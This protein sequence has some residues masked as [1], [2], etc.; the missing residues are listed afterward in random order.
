MISI[1][2]RPLSS[3]WSQ[4]RERGAYI[5]LRTMF[6][7]YRLLGRR[8]FQLMLTPVVG[9]FYLTNGT[10]RAA[11]IHFLRCVHDRAG[12]SADA[13]VPSRLTSFRHFLSFGE[14]IGD[15]IAAWAGDI[16]PDDVDLENAAAFDALR[17]SGRGGIL[18]A[19]H[20]GNMEVCRA[21]S[22]AI[23]TLR[24]T[25]LLHT[26]HSKN[27]TRLMRNVAP[28]SAL[29]IIQTTEMTP[30]T[31]M[32][33]SERVSRGEFIVIAGDRTPVSRSVRVAWAPF[34]G[35]PA[36]FPQGPFIL[37]GLLKCPV[38]LLFCLKHGRRYRLIFEPFSDGFALPRR[39]RAGAAEAWVRRYAERLEYYCMLAP[40]QWFNFFDF[41]AQTPDGLQETAPVDET[42]RYR[43]SMGKRL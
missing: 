39:N 41:W 32:L 1:E 10:A 19:S 6:A 26:K 23:S 9:Y 18:V 22:S 40:L 14:A 5:G 13:R 15:K 35:R 36:P 2:S 8:A 3:H 42:S 7:I 28:D 29:S 38:Q 11:S 20:L 27:F 30:A 4:L 17:Q 33:L 34:L 24:I 16:G 12:A 31:A 25:V 43:Q 21:V 37:A